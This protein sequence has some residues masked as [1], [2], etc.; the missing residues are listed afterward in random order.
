MGLYIRH[1]FGM[2]FVLQILK[3]KDL[4]LDNQNFYD[5]KMI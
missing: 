4:A 5:K 2:G 1:P 3:Y